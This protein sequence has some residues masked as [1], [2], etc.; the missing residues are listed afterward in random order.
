M[1]RQTPMRNSADS[2]ATLFSRTSNSS[3][4]FQSD[5]NSFP[6]SDHPTR[7]RIP[8]IKRASHSHRS[9]ALPQNTNKVFASVWLDA[10]RVLVGTKCNALIVVDA[11]RA[12]AA[13][14]IAPICGFWD[15]DCWTDG[16][17][18][19]SAVTP[20]I[21]SQTE[22]V[23]AAS[24]PILSSPPRHTQPFLAWTPTLAADILQDLPYLQGRPSAAAILMQNYH[25]QQV[26][27]QQ[28]TQQYVFQQPECKGIH[29][30]AVNPSR[31][32]LAV[33][34]G[35]PLE[36]IQIYTL[37]SLEA[38]ALLRCHTDMVFAIQFATDTTLFSG[39]R[40]GQVCFWNLSDTS[41][42]KSTLPRTASSSGSIQVHRPIRNN[43][44]PTN[45]T[46]PTHAKSILQHIPN[47][48]GKLFSSAPPSLSQPLH[49]ELTFI[50]SLHLPKHR[51]RDISLPTPSTLATLT[52]TTGTLK[53][54]DITKS[55]GIQ[56]ATP[57]LDVKLIH[58]Q[59]TVCMSA[60]GC[61]VGGGGSALVVGSMSHVSLVDVRVGAVVSSIKSVDEGWG[62]RSLAS[63]TAMQG[64]VVTVGGGVGRVSFLDLRAMGYLD[65]EGGVSGKDGVV[66]R[67]LTVEEKNGGGGGRGVMK[68]AI[69]T[70]SYCPYGVRL[71]AG[72]GP[73]QLSL[74]GSYAGIWG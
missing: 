54:F 36:T 17:V 37:P 66:E 63:P 21:S 11:V 72:G 69:Y 61:A 73:L 10:E 51:I 49:P 44:P 1:K 28:N 46:P 58:T 33:A 15:N 57:A 6:E 7:P 31:T 64:W 19:P 24:Y 16:V 47:M 74:K 50:G 34:A 8:H 40:D 60:L 23:P 20:D 65:V 56:S 71:F 68:D 55:H 38:Y 39:G 13:H 27:Q 59:E 26:H 48:L 14:S 29:S 53:I 43:P 9:V 35:T 18:H 32:L 62:V 41:T 12:R 70:L 22:Q 42:L 45:P 67:Y 4:V 30:V 52:S 3:S 25:H 5:D 2:L